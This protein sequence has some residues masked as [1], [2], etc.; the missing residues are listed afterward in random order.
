MPNGFDQLQFLF[1]NKNQLKH[2][3]FATDLN[4]LKTLHLKSNRLQELPVKRYEA[5]QTLY[6]QENPLKQYQDNIIK[7]DKSGNAVEII[8]LA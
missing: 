7:G 3:T 1:L 5:L 6:V 4:Q 8:G 2:I